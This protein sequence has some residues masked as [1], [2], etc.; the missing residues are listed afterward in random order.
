MV[1]GLSREVI[2]DSCH[3]WKMTWLP[4]HKNTLSVVIRG[5]SY[6]CGS[7]RV[8]LNALEWHQYEVP[9]GKRLGDIHTDTS[10]ARRLF[11][12]DN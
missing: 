4:S 1:H 7:I 9:T 6:G 12:L 8:C 3:N 5:S 10:T 11:C 2:S